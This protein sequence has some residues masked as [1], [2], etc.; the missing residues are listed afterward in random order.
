[1][2]IPQGEYIYEIREQ[3]RLIATETA[4]LSA[5]RLTGVRTA[6]DGSGNRHEVQA[7]LDAEGVVRAIRLRYVRGPFSRSASYEASGDTL[8]GV[9][10]AVGG[11]NTLEAK[12]GRFKEVDGGLTLFKALLIAHVRSRGQKRWTARVA[13]IDPAT[14]VPKTVKESVYELDSK[15]GTWMFEPAIGERETIVVD[16]AGRILTHTTRTGISSVL[17][18]GKELS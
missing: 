14:L 12:L 13:V 7:D 10:T 11:R 3:G 6:A 9:V 15:P 2:I 16:E 18:P 17:V 4:Q 5:D 8:S 1:V